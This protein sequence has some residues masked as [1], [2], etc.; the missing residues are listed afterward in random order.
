LS[1]TR[2]YA[3]R[4]TYYPDHW[5]EQHL[6]FVVAA[7]F[8]GDRPV[9]AMLDTGSQWCILPVEFATDLGYGAHDEESDTRLHTRFGTITGR[10]V[11]IPLRF[12]AEEGRQVTVEA[13]WFISEGWPG[14]PVLGWK[15]CLERIRFALDP[16]EESF[17]FAEL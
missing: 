9:E 14:P 5:Y 16:G 2:T 13:T 7:C 4:A 15:G 1:L 17:Y 11:R 10:L 6:L 8:V 12:R 3:G